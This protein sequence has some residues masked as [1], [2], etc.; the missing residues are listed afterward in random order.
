MQPSSYAS[1]L[2]RVH[3]LA[4]AAMA[5]AAAPPQPTVDGRERPQT[6]L[7]RAWIKSIGRVPGCEP[8]PGWREGPPPR[9]MAA[10]QGGGV[11]VYA[12]RRSG[13]VRWAN[14]TL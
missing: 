10:P 1:A 12:A 5:A 13:Y 8:P 3:A 4:L 6:P 2:A 11:P 7:E 9:P 14:R